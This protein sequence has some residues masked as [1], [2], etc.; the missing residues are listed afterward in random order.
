MIMIVVNSG[1]Y[2]YTLI[3]HV[4]SFTDCF[5]QAFDQR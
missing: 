4:F 1:I 5:V 3:L 2:N